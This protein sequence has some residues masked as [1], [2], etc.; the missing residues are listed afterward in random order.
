MRRIFLLIFCLFLFLPGFSQDN[1]RIQKPDSNITVPLMQDSLEQLKLEADR[2]A[3]A[4]LAMQKKE[5][6]REKRRM[7][8]R[9]AIGAVFLVVIV[10][11][12]LRKYGKTKS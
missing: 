2:N 4:Q 1:T 8:L 11:I 6:E 7:Y 10:I 5:E 9:I 3:E 12:L